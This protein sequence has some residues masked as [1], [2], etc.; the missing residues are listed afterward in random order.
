L[1]RFY[2]EI[3]GGEPETGIKRGNSTK[4]FNLTSGNRVL[5]S[6]V[7]INVKCNIIIEME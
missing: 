3:I 2:V 6:K 7:L 1:L 5:G 4:F